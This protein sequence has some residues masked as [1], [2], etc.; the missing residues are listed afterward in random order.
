MARIYAEFLQSSG[1]LSSSEMV[2]TSGAKLAYGGPR[3]AHEMIE[4]LI[5]QED[6]GVLFVDEA[7]QLT[8]PHATYEG[9][10]VVDIILTE[11]ENHIGKLVVIFVGYN[12]EMQSFFEHNPGL[13]SRIPYTFQFA[14]FDDA[15]LWDIL[16]NSIEKKYSGKMAI[17][18]GMGG[19]LMRIAIRRLA[20]GRGIRSFGNARSVDNLLAR[21]SDRQ[22][23]RLTEQRRTTHKDPETKESFLFTQEDLIGPDPSKVIL[24]S[25]AWDKLK[26]L[27]GLTEVKASARAMVDMIITNYQREFDEQKPLNFSLNRVFFGSPGT[28]KTTVA[29]LYGQILA[30]I[31]LLSKGEGL[32]SV[33]FFATRPSRGHDY[34]TNLP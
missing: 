33:S 3:A 20:A 31:G 25:P 19:L 16:R 8:A 23:Q 32:Y 30:D 21:I 12:D 17:E 22:A 28:G 1:L 13:A 5:E 9:R 4:E 15:Q 29:K 34:L 26:S 2:E 6:G 27:I 14:D 24:N 7:Y 10:Q 18:G 11:M